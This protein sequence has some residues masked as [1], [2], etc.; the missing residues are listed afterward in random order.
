MALPPTLE[1]RLIEK[2]QLTP[3]V[4][5]L[6]FERT[7]G[8][9]FQFEAGQWVSLILPH[10]EGELRRAYSIASPP[11]GSPRFEVAITHV[12]G[13]P[14]STFLHDLAIG[15]TLTAIGPQGFFTRPF[16]KSGPSLFVATGTGITPLRSMIRTA[17]SA[18]TTMPLWLVCGVRTEG[19]ILYRDEL[20][21]LAKANPHVRVDFTLSRAADDWTGRRG[22]VQTHVK[23]LW[24]ELGALGLGPQHVYICGLQKM[25]GAVRELLRKEMGVPREQVHAERYD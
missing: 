25:V 5:E 3:A 13:G 24:E 14:G 12:A 19:D 18:G 20:E 10:P 9:T 2:R 7:D 15:S 6:T 23:E 4:R 8:A 21:A 1:I 11:F 16:H 22:Y 17:A